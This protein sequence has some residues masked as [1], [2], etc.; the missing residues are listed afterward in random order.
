MLSL[1]RNRKYTFAPICSHHHYSRA[2]FYFFEPLPIR[3]KPVK[4]ATAIPYD[5]IS[6]VHNFQSCGLIFWLVLIKI[7]SKPDLVFID[8]VVFADGKKGVSNWMEESFRDSC[9][10]VE[11]DFLN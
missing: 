4:A 6:I 5:Q 11:V 7:A 3:V 1:P 9:V 2:S 8:C 10:R